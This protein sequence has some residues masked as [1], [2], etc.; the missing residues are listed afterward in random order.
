MYDFTKKVILKQEAL[1]DVN[2]VLI[3]P[4][5][6][7]PI[8]L[9]PVFVEN[10]PIEF[11]IQA[12]VQLSNKM[13]FDYIQEI[14]KGVRKITNEAIVL[15]LQALET[16]LNESITLC[17]K[18]K[19]RQIKEETMQEI[20]D[21]KIKSGTLTQILR[22]TQGPINNV[23]LAQLNDMAYR[24]VQ[25]R[26]LN[27]KLDERALKNKDFYNKLDQQVEAVIKKFNFE[28]LKK[29]HKDIGEFIGQCPI[30]LNDCFESLQNGTCMCIGLEVERSEACIADPSLL[31]IKGIIP[32][33]FSGESYQDQAIFNLKADPNAHGG[34]S[35]A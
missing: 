20:Q 8:R 7:T 27:K 22:Q 35:N 1:T 13:L 10:P 26:G 31:K 23:Q 4:T 14:Q 9:V 11:L 28:E 18:L 29:Q 21:A 34:F 25:K 5:G 12:R 33:F 19:N 24:A 3:L 17:Y 15:K 32:T 16:V 6:E 2:G 30:S